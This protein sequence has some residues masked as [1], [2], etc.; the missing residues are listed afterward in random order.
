MSLLLTLLMTRMISLSP[1]WSEAI[2]PIVMGHDTILHT[3]LRQRTWFTS[4]KD[5][6]PKPHSFFSWVITV[7][8]TFAFDEFSAGPDHR[9]TEHI[10]F[11]S[12]M[13]APGKMKP[14]IQ[15]LT[16]L[17]KTEQIS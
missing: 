3:S 7:Q 13:H 10:L 9:K 1:C 15:K 17:T 8:A 12:L 5:Q 6:K 4:S 11:I 14:D 16:I 2:S